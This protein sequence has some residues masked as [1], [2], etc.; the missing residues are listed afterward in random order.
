MPAKQGA[1]SRI[2][3]YAGSVA[4]VGTFLWF[5]F[6][7]FGV[8]SFVYAQSPYPS[9]PVISGITW[10]P[11]ST[12]VYDASGSD[13]WPITWAD[14]DHLYTAFG[15]GW[16]F[17]PKVPSKLSL[18]FA[19]V[20]GPA[21]GFSGLN[22]RSQSGEQTGDGSGGKK[23]SGMLMIDGTLY[24]WV[25][26]ADNSGTQC[27]LAWS[28]DHSETWTWSNWKFAELGYCAFLNF[29]KNYAGARDGYVYMYSP[30]TPSAYSE[31]DHVV[32]TR[33]L[34]SQLSN[35]AAYEFFKEFDANGN[36]VWITDIAQRGAVF[37]LL[38]G[39][40]RLDVTYN[41]A[42]GRYFM[43]MRSR[44][45]MGGLNQFSIYDAP[46]PWGPW[47]TI[48]YTESWEGGALSTSNGGWGESQH[49]PS[50]WISADGKTFYLIFAG[51][52]SFAVRKAT[53][54]VLGTDVTPPAAPV[55]LTVQLQI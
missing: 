6:L 17:D 27:Q 35:R 51:N 12:I 31:T 18:G 47:T 38:G 8:V 32:L 13:T 45:K 11:S 16:G 55:A 33:V 40:N 39:A 26:N 41:A 25:R 19:R 36:P 43:T 53:L 46:E 9:S 28:A 7:I 21:P 5:F 42:L 49:I 22:I 4:E 24:M 50:K 34:K 14:D 52:D 44:A 29:G 3:Q 20:D 15:D 10:A 23:A 48:Y 37:T 2:D 1:Y 54:N 30:D